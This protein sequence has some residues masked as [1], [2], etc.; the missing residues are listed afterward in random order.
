MNPTLVLT[1]LAI[2]HGWDNPEKAKRVVD[3]IPLGRLAGMDNFVGK[4]FFIYYF[5]RSL[6]IQ[7]T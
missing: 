7:S 3:I 1:P 5:L 4:S 6:N 2:T